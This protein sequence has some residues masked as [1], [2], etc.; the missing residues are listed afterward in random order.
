MALKRKRLLPV[1]LNTLAAMSKIE[2]LRT[3][4]ERLMSDPDYAKRAADSWRFSHS[5]NWPNGGVLGPLNHVRD[6]ID[7]G[8]YPKLEVIYYVAVCFASYLSGEVATLD[9]AFNVGG[10]PRA[11]DARAEDQA[12]I[13]RNVMFARVACWINKGHTQHKAAEMVWRER[14]RGVP[15]ADTIATEYGKWCA[16]SQRQMIA[17]FQQLGVTLPVSK[18]QRRRKGEIKA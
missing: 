6:R 4:E 3:A 13:D 15:D 12:R 9:R 18:K 11:G 1:N 14:G 16:E 17:V 7:A 2:P 5:F 10:R 8:L